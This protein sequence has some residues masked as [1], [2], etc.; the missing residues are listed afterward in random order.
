MWNSFTASKA[1]NSVLG[2][3]NQVSQILNPVKECKSLTYYQYEQ[4]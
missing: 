1:M 4:I 2:K 3:F